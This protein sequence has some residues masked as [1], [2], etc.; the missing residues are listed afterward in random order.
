V[1]VGENAHV[2]IIERHQSLNEIQFVQ[3]SYGDFAQNVVVGF[4]NSKRYP[5]R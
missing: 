2:Q 3:F 1:I 5:Y 4:E